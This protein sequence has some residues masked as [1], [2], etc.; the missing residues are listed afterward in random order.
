[1][2]LDLTIEV[3]RENNGNVAAVEHR[4]IEVPNDTSKTNFLRM[5]NALED[6]HPD[7]YKK[8]KKEH[9]RNSFDF[10]ILDVKQNKGDKK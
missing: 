1:M 6:Q 7:L 2:K 8:W 5:F 9:S 4:T 10:V 3:I